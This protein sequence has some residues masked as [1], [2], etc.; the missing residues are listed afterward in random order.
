MPRINYY[1]FFPFSIHI[2]T[3]MT[4]DRYYIIVSGTLGIWDAARG[5]QITDN[6]EEKKNTF[7]NI[8]VRM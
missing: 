4:I 2:G 8:G 7:V 3:Y 1:F 6:Y 5:E